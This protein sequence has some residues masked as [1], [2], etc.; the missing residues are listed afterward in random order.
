MCVFFFFQNI[1]ISNP[2]DIENPKEI[3]NI[4]TVIERHE[5]VIEK[6]E[7]E[8]I[9]KIKELKELETTKIELEKLEIE[10]I[11]ETIAIAPKVI[12]LP[13]FLRHV[14]QLINQAKEKKV[15]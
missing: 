1:K 12:L 9:N 6:L 5:K 14:C 13:Y 2:R 10:K 11:N 3:E 7:I 4:E 8:K 15:S